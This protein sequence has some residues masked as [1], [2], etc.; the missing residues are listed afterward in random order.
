MKEYDAATEYNG[1]EGNRVSTEEKRVKLYKISK[2][3]NT[4]SLI[5]LVFDLLYLC[6]RQKEELDFIISSIKEG[7][8]SFYFAATPFDFTVIFAL[9]MGLL[10]VI[11]GILIYVLRKKLKIE[12]LTR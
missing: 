6:Y 2:A 5:F 7:A 3:V 12:F 9:C 4:L 8:A 11:S 10:F 1:V